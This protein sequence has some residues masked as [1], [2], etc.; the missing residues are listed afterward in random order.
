MQTNINQQF[1]NEDGEIHVPLSYY[2]GTC[3]ERGIYKLCAGTV[4]VR[5]ILQRSQAYVVVDNRVWRSRKA[6]NEPQKQLF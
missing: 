3:K 4:D 1:I 6:E 5:A 2:F